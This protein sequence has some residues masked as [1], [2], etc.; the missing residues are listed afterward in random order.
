MVYPFHGR[1]GMQKYVYTLGKF[2]NKKGIDVE[3]VTSSAGNKNIRKV[4][5]ENV[6]F[7]LLNQKIGLEYKKNISID[8]HYENDVS[9]T[10]K[11]LLNIPIIRSIIFLFQYILFTIKVAVYLANNKFDI[12]HSF[13]SNSLAYLLFFRKRKPVIVQPF[14]NEEFKHKGIRNIIITMPDRVFLKYCVKKADRVSSQGKNNT[15]DILQIYNIDAEKIVIFKNGVELTHINNC[16]NSSDLKRSQ[17]GFDEDDLVLITVN[18]LDKS[19]R[20]DLLIKTLKILV[21]D[22]YSNIKLIII[23][24]G[25]EEAH[26]KNIISKNNLDNNIVLK[27][28]I[29]DKSLYSYL[30]LSNIYVNPAETE[31]FLLSV[32]EAMACH[33]PI[34]SIKMQEDGVINDVNGFIV[35][36]DPKHI[37]NKVI[38]ITRDVNIESFKSASYDIIK[39][40]DWEIVANEITTAYQ[41]LQHIEPPN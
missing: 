19:K 29:S 38:K 17:L 24:S 30:N 21:N 7:T 41:S 26:I 1:G 18:R 35:P 11:Y 13:K 27:K 34:I 39:S 3:I 36:L 8:N 15:N 9:I 5:Y 12:L 33:L 37:A 28:N 31:Y 6:D 23:G 4:T 22:G 20:I 32:M 2:L 16:I 40:Y 14:A 10:Y 25:P